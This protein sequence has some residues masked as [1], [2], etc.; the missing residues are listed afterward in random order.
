MEYDESCRPFRKTDGAFYPE[1]R[2]WNKLL[3]ER[4]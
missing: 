3:E 1:T 2:E 4:A